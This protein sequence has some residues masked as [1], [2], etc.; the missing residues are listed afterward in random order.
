MKQ[1]ELPPDYGKAP[2]R[3]H[4]EHRHQKRRHRVT[5]KAWVALLVSAVAVAVLIVQR[6]WPRELALMGGAGLGLLA[7]MILN[8]VERMRYVLRR[9]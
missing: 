5:L 4:Q 6:D 1:I 7:Y 2:K 9:R 3:R 8:T